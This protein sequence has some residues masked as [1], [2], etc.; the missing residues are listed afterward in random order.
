[1][2]ETN[3]AILQL[4]SFAIDKTVETA[5]NNAVGWYWSEMKWWYVKPSPNSYSEY[6]QGSMVSHA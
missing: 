4:Q 2:I 3:I 5:Q 1:M 6:G